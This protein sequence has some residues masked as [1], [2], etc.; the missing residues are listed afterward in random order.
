M[1]LFSLSVVPI[2]CFS[3]QRKENREQP[4]RLHIFFL[5]FP[6]SISLPPPPLLQHTMS[7]GG[8][9]NAKK[10][11]GIPDENVPQ[12][13]IAVDTHFWV[14]T[15]TFEIFG[16]YAMNVGVF[17]RHWWQLHVVS[18]W[19]EKDQG[20]HCPQHAVPVELLGKMPKSPAENASMYICNTN[21]IV[22][23]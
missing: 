21:Y 1:L 19:R 5:F 7:V 8:S 17:L 12:I 14:F 3:F 2:A 18:F 11:R 13:L 22:F 23:N 4:C 20:Q 6:P 15:A 9:T 16:N 10:S